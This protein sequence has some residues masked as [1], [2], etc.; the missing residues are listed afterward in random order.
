MGRQYLKETEFSGRDRS[1]EKIGRWT[2]LEFSRRERSGRRYRCT[3]YWKAKCDC[4]TVSEISTL[5]G[6]SQ[7]CGCLRKETSRCIN[8]SHGKA[9]KHHLYSTWKSMRS[10]CNNKRNPKYN[11][12]GGRG[13]SICERWNNFELFVTD[14]EPSWI[15]G[16]S[17][18]RV[19]NNGNY[20]PNNCIWA[21]PKIQ[22][23]FKTNSRIISHGGESKT[24]SEWS[25]SIGIKYATLWR[26][27]KLGWD[28][29]KALTP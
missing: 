24:I 22:S 15:S 5:N 7:S 19:D 17:I 25:E 26:R 28:I 12:Y 4:G 27:I 3:I 16:L 9:N 29:P 2:I 6:M 11:N 8:L 20:H 21:T 18:H 23:N 13:I 1:G 14:M 10:R